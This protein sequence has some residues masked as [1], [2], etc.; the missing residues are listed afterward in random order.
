MNIWDFLNVVF[1]MHKKVMQDFLF[2]YC[3]MICK[4]F[5]YPSPPR[6]AALDGEFRGIVK[7]LYG[8]GARK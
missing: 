4:V 2:N 1:S 5:R 8:Y 3:N 7:A 6:P